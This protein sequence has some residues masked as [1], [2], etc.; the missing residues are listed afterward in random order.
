MLLDDHISKLDFSYQ[1]TVRHYVGMWRSH[2]LSMKALHPYRKLSLLK[3]KIDKKIQY[4]RKGDYHHKENEKDLPKWTERHHY[5]AWEK[6][7]SEVSTDLDPSCLSCNFSANFL[8]LKT[9]SI[10]QFK[11]ATNLDHRHAWWSCNLSVGNSVNES[12]FPRDD[13]LHQG[14]ETVWPHHCRWDDSVS[15][16]KW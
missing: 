4:N 1:L 15:T 8:R 5:W 6:H 11:V 3:R 10:T 14:K 2:P 12:D 13:L 7:H 9:V 16:L